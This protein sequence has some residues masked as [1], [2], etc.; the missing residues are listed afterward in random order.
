MTG[1]ESLELI[2]AMIVDTRRRYHFEDGRLHLFWGYLD[3]AV[4]LLVWGVAY[5][6]LLLS[7]KSLDTANLSFCPPLNRLIHLTSSKVPLFLF[8]SSVFFADSR[9]IRWFETRKSIDF[10]IL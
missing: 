8:F 4:A 1:R 2:S 5:F 10:A 3:I 9:C 7:G 6:T